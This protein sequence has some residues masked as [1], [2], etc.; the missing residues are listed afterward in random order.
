MTHAITIPKL[1]LTMEECT[2]I[3]WYFTD[4]ER[5]EKGKP[6]FA[7]ET[8]KIVSDVDAE[9]GGFLQCTA[10]KNATL[11]VGGLVGY[12]HAGP[13]AALNAVKTDT[14]ALVVS[15]NAAADHSRVRASPAAPSSAVPAPVAASGERVQISPLAR[16]MAAEAGLD[17]SR[18]VG[19]G[20]NGVIRKRDVE[21]TVRTPSASVSPAASSGKE[22][23]RRP[24]GRLRR[25]IAQRM[26]HSLATTAQMTGFGTV[27]MTEVTQWRQAL[28]KERDRL[29]A[30]ITFTDIVI[31][32]AAAVLAEMPQINAYI[33]GDEVVTWRDVNI[34]FAVALDDGLIVPVVRNADRLKLVEISRLRAALIDKARSGQLGR[35]D[36]EGGTFSI[37]N[38][39]SYGGDFETPILAPPQSAILG[40]GQISEQAVVRNGQILIR[41][42]MSMSMTFDHRLIDGAVAGRFRA[43]FKALLEQPALWMAAMV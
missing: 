4:G 8:E 28:V 2:L 36:V 31:K 25:A 43:R 37:S 13:E 33:D 38:F 29:G 20:P 12:I 41:S 11:P 7:I 17:P 24:L 10:A 39:G 23:T 1:G 21:A 19:T 6:L 30:R 9:H 14:P 5:I 34:G 22:V 35:A 18:I 15:P 3:E 32:A 26:M 27:D 40:I 42:M 16:R